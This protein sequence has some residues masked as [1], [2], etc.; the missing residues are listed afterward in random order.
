[1]KK[2]IHLLCSTYYAYQWSNQILQFNTIVVL[3]PNQLNCMQQLRKDY[4]FCDFLYADM[5]F[6]GEYL[7]TRAFSVHTM[8]TY[9]VSICR[10]I[11]T[12]LAC[13]PI[14]L[15]TNTM[16]LIQCRLF[17]FHGTCY[18][19]KLLSFHPSVRLILPLQL[20]RKVYWLA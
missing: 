19:A 11:F 20:W 15:P 10:N 8:N 17:L 3:N 12:C 18:A 9:I 13:S 5:E 4:P 16:V 14:K 6:E 7:K 2:L 1:M